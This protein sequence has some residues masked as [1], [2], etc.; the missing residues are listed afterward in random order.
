MPSEKLRLDSYRD[1][2]N[3]NESPLENHLFPWDPVSSALLVAGQPG[4]TDER[5]RHVSTN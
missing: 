4:G 1:K 5:G 2:A 3:P